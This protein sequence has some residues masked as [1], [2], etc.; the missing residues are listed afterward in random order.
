ME[1]KLVCNSDTLM[2]V[3][4]CYCRKSILVK[5]YGC[6]EILID[7]RLSVAK[8]YH[9]FCHMEAD[10]TIELK[11]LDDENKTGNTI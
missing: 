11:D 8:R 9:I 2:P 4:C 1:E 6:T 5:D 3:E 7:G 10:H